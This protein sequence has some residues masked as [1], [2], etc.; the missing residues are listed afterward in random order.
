MPNAAA[1]DPHT[2]VFDRRGDIWFT[3]QNGNFVGKLATETGEV[4]LL[5]VPTPS[6][7]PYGIVMDS[8]DR[9]WFVE[10]GTNKLGTVDTGAMAIEEFTIPQSGAR[11]RR[12]GVTS[13]D[14]V[15]YVD[16]GRGFLGRFLPATREFSE[17]RM[18]GGSGSRPYGMA[19]DDRDRIWFV[20]TGRSPNRFIGFDPLAEEFFSVVAIPSGG[21]SVRHMYFHP[22]T[23]EIWFGTDVNTVGRARLDPVVP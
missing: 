5:P 22:A 15:W 10:F 14:T 19:V 3:V 9:P 6:S 21:G 17:W 16:H 20:E 8:A 2:L 23:R 12:L 11:P 1:R 7:R 4:I 18:P 13:D